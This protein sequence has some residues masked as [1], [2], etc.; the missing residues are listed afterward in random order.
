MKTISS[1]QNE[2]FKWLLQLTQSA[3]HR[4]SEQKAWIEGDR[5]C[6]SYLAQPNAQGLAPRKA[7][8]TAVVTE[9]LAEPLEAR[10]QAQ[11]SDFW[12]LPESL[13]NELSQ[14]GSGPGWGLIIPVPGVEAN[15][16]PSDGVVLDRLQDPGNVGSLMRS[17]AAFGIRKVYCLAPTADA[18]SPKALRAGMGAHFS[19]EIVEDISV[20]DFLD[21]VKQNGLRL[22]S[23]ANRS[24]AVALTD[25]SLDLSPPGLWVFGR[26]SEGVSKALLRESRSVRIPQEEGVESLNVAAAAAIC[27]FEVYRRRHR[28]T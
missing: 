13:F 8:A 2:H 25:P 14:F 12:V 10:L 24:D 26:E 9:S 23:T 6:D 28:D 18:W 5:L 19:L 4:R 15:F 27:F 7:G 17:A 22:F 3:R 20:D 11:V 1:R 16:L 21:Q